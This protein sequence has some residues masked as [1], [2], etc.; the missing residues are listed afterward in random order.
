M[1]R[2]LSISFVALSVSLASCGESNEA[3]TNTNTVTAALSVSA[4][5]DIVSSEREPVRLN[6]SASQAGVVTW[7]QISGPVVT[8][9]NPNILSPQFR[10]PNVRDTQTIA[11]RLSVS[12]NNGGSVSDDVTITVENRANGPDGP[13]PQGIPNDGNNRRDRARNDRDNRRMLDNREVRTYDGTNNNVT[14]VDWGASFIHL[15][16]LSAAAYA[17]GVSSLA[18]PNRPS[19]RLVS[20]AVVNQDEGTSIDSIKSASDF[21]WQW[22]QFIDHDLDLTD[23]AEE[24]AHISVPSG[25]I[26][27]DPTGTG[28]VIIPFSRALF[29]PDTGFTTSNPREQEN[30]ITS[31]IDGSMVYGS[32]E[33]RN[34]ALRVGTDSPYLKTSDGNLLPFNEDSLTNANGFISDPTQLFLAGDI[35]ANEQLGLATMHTLF[36]REHNRIAAQLTNEFPNNTADEVFEA[37]RRLVVAKIQK[38]T[39][40]EWLPALI[41]ENAIQDY[42]GYDSTLNPSVFNEFS[43][44]AFRLGHSMV[45][46]LLWRLDENGNEIADG[47]VNLAA[48]FFTAPQILTEETSIDPILRGLAGQTHQK[49]DTKVVHP[50]R[51]FLFGAPGDGGLDL[52][53]LNIQRGRDHGL[54][55]YN[56]MR[57][58]MGL[59]AVTNFDEI[60]TD[61]TLVTALSSTY[62]T[63]DDIDLWVGG[64]SEDPVGDSQLGPLFQAILVKQFSDIR[65]GDRF[66]YQNDLNDQERDRISN[67]TLAEIIRDNTEI[68]DELQD[69]VFLTSN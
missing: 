9:D 54:P 1:Q 30:E 66:W 33:D 59:A 31:W 49:L 20:N 69:N 41:G 28:G 47:H 11:L 63:V 60:S 67:V 34:M 51:N 42:S 65:N 25:D 21:V 7:T 18:G 43:A 13:S 38:I 55:D 40:D 46:E 44:G 10:A 62:N 23:G 57:V 48:A 68:G 2:L 58:A 56:S 22:G 12:D 32:S 39:Y 37:T 3:D 15:Q 6:G 53:S 8:L 4:G 52:P 50:L 17:D 36:V 45:N 16:R 35:R 27:F 29:D 24:E 19:A 64:L 5:V 14:Y 26:Y 61:T